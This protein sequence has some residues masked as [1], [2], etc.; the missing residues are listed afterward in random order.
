MTTYIKRIKA[1]RGKD[2]LVDEAQLFI[3]EGVLPYFYK[4]INAILNLTN[5]GNKASLS[6]KEILFLQEL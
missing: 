5:F 2:A 1:Y 4:F 3:M 6:K